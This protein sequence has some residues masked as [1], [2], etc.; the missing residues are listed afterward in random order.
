MV[1]TTNTPPGTAT[2][3]PTAF[4]AMVQRYGTLALLRFLGALLAFTALHVLLRLPLLVLL[5]MCEALM[6][7]IDAP[8]A[9][10]FPGR[11]TP[12]AAYGRGTA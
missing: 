11:P 3:P 10:R 4:D 2:S 7:R 8:V 6:A 5:R 1:A 12:P 9:A